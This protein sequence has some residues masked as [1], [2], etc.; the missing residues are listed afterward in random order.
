M[1]AHQPAGQPDF[2]GVRRFE[3]GLQGGDL[4][5]VDPLGRTTEPGKALPMAALRKS[6]PLPI[7][8]ALVED[9]L[10]TA[11]VEV[12]FA[13][14]WRHG[15]ADLTRAER[16]AVAGVTGHVAESVTAVLL[17]QLEWRVLWHLTG[18]GRHGVDL[19]FLAPGDQVVAVEVKGTLVAGRVPRLSH[20]DM[21]QMSASWVDKAD[22][23]GMAEL[24]LE[25]ADVFGGIVIINFSDLNWRIGLTPD[26]VSLIPVT[27]IQQLT[28]LRWLTSVGWPRG[29]AV[30]TAPDTVAVPRPTITASTRR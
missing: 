15:P 28:D 1:G 27:T 19:V 20:R 2:P 7:D 23:P 5:F 4:L 9:C 16:C 13:R 18:S 3:A 12:V 26:F 29:A 8:P 10:G 22:N 11:P 17:D 25:S 24:G 21:A 6:A 30:P 14:G